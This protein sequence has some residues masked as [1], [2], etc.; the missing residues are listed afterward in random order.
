MTAGVLQ[1]AHTKVIPNP[2]PLAFFDRSASRLA[3][4]KRIGVD[5]DKPVVAF[6]AWKAW[7]VS[8]DMNK[9]YDLLEQAIKIA[10][11]QQTFTF[12]ILGHDGQLIPPQ[13]GALWIQPDGSEE[14]VV[15]F[16]RAAD[17]VLGAS[18]EEVLPTVIQEAQGLGVPGVVPA[19]TGYEDVVVDGLTGLHFSQGDAA[20]FADKICA[21]VGSPA[22][23]E[24]L[25]NQAA[26]RAARLWHPD[27][28]RLQ[29]AALY[30][31]IFGGSSRAL[32]R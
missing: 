11:S 22:L 23:R 29:Y 21:L 10:R 3:A 9:G 28:V 16:F 14:Q 18:R 15:N 24:K 8:G 6:V 2:L 31:E 17:L 30:A 26:T 32:T 25:G 13:L 27:R 12:M 4:K 5:P 7:K 1:E 20:D 19:A